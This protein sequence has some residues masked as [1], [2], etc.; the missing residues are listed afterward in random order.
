MS[1][2]EI[3]SRLEKLEQQYRQLQEVVEQLQRQ[4]GRQA[5]N[6]VTDTDNSERPWVEG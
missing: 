5:D 2:E 4:V 6:V 1:E 3:L